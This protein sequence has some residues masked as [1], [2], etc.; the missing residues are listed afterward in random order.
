MI[1]EHTL[2][3]KPGL[4][5]LIIRLPALLAGGVACMIFAANSNDDFV[6]GALVI[7]GL[8]LFIISFFTSIG[9]TAVSPNESRVV[10]L[11]GKYVGTIH[12]QGLWWVNPFTSRIKVSVRVRNFDSDKLKVND[13]EGN[14]VEIGA[15]VVWRVIETAEAIFEVDDYEDYVQ[16]QSE[17]ALRNLATQYPYDAHDGESVA[18]RSHASTI[19]EQLKVEVQ[20]RLEKA[21]VEVL[22]A[23]ISHLAYAQE[24]ASAM[25]QRQQADAIIAARSKI[26]DGA[27]GMV[28]MA[29]I[30]LGENNIVQLDEDRKAAMVSNLLVVLCGDKSTQPVVNTGSIY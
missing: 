11:F 3:P 16:V 26:V 22:E 7:S 29:L 27:V 19:A 2:S 28:E 13:K 5:V 15:V 9:F 12:K 18:L 20:D 30:K 1:K 6:G 23:R 8:V 14:P 17:A 24:I 21:G 10:Q 25:L 4:P